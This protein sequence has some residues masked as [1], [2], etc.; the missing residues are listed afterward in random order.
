MHQGRLRLLETSQRLHHSIAYK[1]LNETIQ[2]DDAKGFWSALERFPSVEPETELAM[3]ELENYVDGVT[4][5]IPL[6]FVYADYQCS[7]MVTDTEIVTM[8]FPPYFDCF[9]FANTE[10]GREL[11]EEVSLWMEPLNAIESLA[12]ERITK[13]RTARRAAKRKR[14]KLLVLRH[15]WPAVALL[16]AAWTLGTI[17]LAFE[18]IYA[19]NLENR[20]KYSLW[21]SGQTASSNLKLTPDHGRP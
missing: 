3:C 14:R 6:V 20:K 1:M 17:A 12:V 18:L 10:I 15:L 5:A 7:D 4:L 19:R 8:Q 13:T 16:A 9:M 11:T 2:Q 21:G